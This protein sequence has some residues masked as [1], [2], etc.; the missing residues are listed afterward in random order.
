[1]SQCMLVCSATLNLVKSATLNIDNSI[2]EKILSLLL[3]KLIC[4]FDIY[5][6]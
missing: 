3:V 1:M 4:S 6:T 2:N 5:E